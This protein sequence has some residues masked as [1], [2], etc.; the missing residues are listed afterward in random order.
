MCAHASPSPSSSSSSAVNADDDGHEDFSE[1]DHYVGQLRVNHPEH[2]DAAIRL[3]REY[4]GSPCHSG[5]STKGYAHARVIWNACKNNSILDV[6]KTSQACILLLGMPQVVNVSSL[7]EVREACLYFTAICIFYGAKPRLHLDSLSPFHIRRVA[8]SGDT[9][10]TGN[11]ESDDIS[12]AM[13]CILARAVFIPHICPLEPNPDLLA[14]RNPLKRARSNGRGARL[15]RSPPADARLKIAKLALN[16]A[17][18]AVNMKII[19]NINAKSRILL[20]Q[21][22]QAKKDLDRAVKN[23]RTDTDTLTF[24][25]SHSQ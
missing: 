20:Q 3:L 21:L 8:D 15:P 5:I 12:V 25:A 14:P 23:S 11:T 4:V 7:A 17:E 18:A 19:S 24:T 16:K 13:R 9:G 1:D 22:N 2:I 10:N 6:Q